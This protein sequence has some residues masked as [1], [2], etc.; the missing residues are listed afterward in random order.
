MARVGLVIA[1][2]AGLTAL[3]LPHT[4][5]VAVHAAGLDLPWWLLTLMFALVEICV[6]HVQV[7][8]EAQTVSLCE[9]PL[10]LGL[11]FT[12]PGTLVLARV[13]GPLLVFVLVRR[14]PTVKVLYNVALLSA[15]MSVALLVFFAIHGGSITTTWTAW[16][17]SFAAVIAAGSLDAV[18]TTLVIGASEGRLPWRD[19]VREPLVESARACGVATLALVAVYALTLDVAAA[20]PLVAVGVLLLF[21]YRAYAELNERHLSLERLYRF[22]QAVTS[23]PEVDEVLR[24]VLT[25]AKE[26]LHAENAEITFMATSAG[27]KAVRVVLPPSGRLQRLEAEDLSGAD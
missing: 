6:L 27:R 19:L 5:G 25:Q 22:S 18:A 26:M 10:V 7:R 9:I 3:L 23:S 8:R 21:A 15:N 17:A 20:V 12:D 2:L 11:F 4:T 14:Q 16:A 1:A 24:S 13:L